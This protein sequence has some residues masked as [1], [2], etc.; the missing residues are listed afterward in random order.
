[1]DQIIPTMTTAQRI[2]A[3]R[4]ELIDADIP[5]NLVE[6]LT[7]IATHELMN[8]GIYIKAE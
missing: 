4:K 2:A 3:F 5:T 8:G 7:I 1:M 6:Q